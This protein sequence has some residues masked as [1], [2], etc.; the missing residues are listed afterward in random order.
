MT[1]QAFV[2]FHAGYNAISTAMC[3]MTHEIDVNSNIQKKLREEIGDVLK[4]TDGKPIY[5]AIN[6]MKYLDAVINEA[7]RLYPIG[8]F[9]DRKLC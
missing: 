3:F 2:F 7:L 5:E 9:L 4:Q 1:A 8:P 6:C